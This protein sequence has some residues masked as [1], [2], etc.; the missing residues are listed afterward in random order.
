MPAPILRRRTTFQSERFSLH[1]ACQHFLDFS[2]ANKRKYALQA[3]KG[4][5]D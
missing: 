2:A 1:H 5:E 3:I 4:E